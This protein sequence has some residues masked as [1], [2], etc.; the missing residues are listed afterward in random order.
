MDE[1]LTMEENEQEAVGQEWREEKNKSGDGGEE[2]KRREYG[3]N[4]EERGEEEGLR[5]RRKKR[6]RRGGKEKVCK[7][8]QRVRGREVEKLFVRDSGKL[9]KVPCKPQGDAINLYLSHSCL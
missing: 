9:I 6:T 4:D 7:R 2:M 5:E 8:P 1:D 3:E